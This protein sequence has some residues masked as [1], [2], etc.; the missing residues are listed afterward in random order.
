MREMSEK[1]KKRTPSYKALQAAKR[2]QGSNKEGEPR[3]LFL[4]PPGLSLEEFQ[5]IIALAFDDFA[6][7]IINDY[8]WKK[9]GL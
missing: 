9:I 5:K 7:E 8:E 4:T 3:L 6:D 2:L 1:D